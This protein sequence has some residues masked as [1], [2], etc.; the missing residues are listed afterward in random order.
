MSDDQPKKFRTVRA[1]IALA[2]VLTCAVAY[3][4]SIGPA[5]WLIKQG[6]L[7]DAVLNFYTPLTRLSKVCQPV[8]VFLQWYV[9]LFTNG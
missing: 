1:A 6:Y 9:S 4:L 8:Y 5:Y 7:S 2:A 3:V